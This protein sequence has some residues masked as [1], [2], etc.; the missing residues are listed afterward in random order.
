MDIL[1]I[2]IMVMSEVA[3]KTCNIQGV[4]IFLPDFKFKLQTNG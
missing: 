3:K 4:P 2:I 1:I